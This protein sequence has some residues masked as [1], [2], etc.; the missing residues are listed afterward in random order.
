MTTTIDDHHVVGQLGSDFWRIKVQPELIPSMAQEFDW[1]R[2]GRRVMIDAKEGIISWMSPSSLHEDL[3]SASDKVVPM[4]GVILK[5]HVKD[6][7][8][9]RWRGPDD[10]QNVG[11]EA[12][13]AYYIGTN[14]EGWY[15]ADR[16]EGD[17]AVLAF[18]SKTPPDLVV[19]VEVSHFDEDK[20]QRY[21]ELGVREMWRVD[22]KKGSRQ[23][24]IEI[25]DLQ[26]VGGPKPVVNSLVLNRLGS[27]ILPDAFQM[28][29][30][31]KIN[32]LSELLN[33][34][35]A[36]VNRPKPDDEPDSSP[37]SASV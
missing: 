35:L 2:L 13:A 30:S 25:L 16:E 26:A 3:A 18:E 10:P 24:Q 7:R 4:A 21:A 5:I 34:N 33:D 27:S 23:I 31:G 28:A 8:A 29:R 36:K 22:G 19:E 12:D 17:E 15:A 6:K 1:N 9:N 20:P 32:M 37:P 14:A 11:L